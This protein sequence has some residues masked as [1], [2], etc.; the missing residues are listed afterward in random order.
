MRL[1]APS[2]N[3]NIIA[4]HNVIMSLYS[5]IYIDCLQIYCQ[6][7]IVVLWLCSFAFF[8][9]FFFDLSF[10]KVYLLIDI[11]PGGLFMIFYRFFNRCLIFI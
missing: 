7:N 1:K 11:L 8:F 10:D 4:K 5:Q 6:I 2:K 3:F 9:F